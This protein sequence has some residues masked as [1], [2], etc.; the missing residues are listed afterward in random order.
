[1]ADFCTGGLWQ[2]MVEV[3]IRFIDTEGAEMIRIVAAFW[4][5]V[6]VSGPFS[7]ALAGK[8][9]AAPSCLAFF[10]DIWGEGK[11][12]VLDR[13]IDGT[14]IKTAS[15]F[16][17]VTG[18][19][20]AGLKIIKGGDFSGW[21][22][23]KIPLANICFE[24]TKLAGANFSNVRARGIGFI[25]SD[26]SGSNMRGAQMPAILLRN[27]NLTNVEAQGAD[28]SGGQ[29]DGGWF[30]GGI[31]GWN[32]D[33]A[34][35]TGFTFDCGITLSDGCPVYQGGDPVRANRANFTQANLDSFGLYN[36]E[37][38]GAILDRTII[39]PEQ[40]P[41]LRGTDIRGDV[42]FKGGDAE[43]GI[44]PDEMTILLEKN[45]DQ[46]VL[47]AN[48][49]F[50]CFDARSKVE[51]E[52]CGEYG[53]ELRLAD[54]DIA[55]LYRQAKALD[56]SVKSS[57][58]RWLKLRNRCNA[59][60]YA[61]QCIRESYSQRKGEL[62]GILGESQWLALGAEA[63]FV[64]DVLPLPTGF[65]Q[66]DLFAKITPAL[67]SAS[68]TDIMVMRGADGLYTIKGTAVGAN[69]H[70]CSLSASHLYFD[71]QSGWYI[72]VSEGRVTPIFRIFQD[73]LEIF[74][75]GRPDYDKYPGALDFISCGMRASFS[76]TRRIKVSAD[77]LA[78]YRKSFDE[79]M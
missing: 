20:E 69:A 9:L 78:R 72:P 26:L 32:I 67:V 70:M 41:E 61:I 28:F 16:M 25:A 60:E 33:G 37:L 63:L 19:R 65:A 76:E 74:E 22:F 45:A 43:V 14:S 52:I 10:G 71:T 55:A 4:G 53:E 11:N 24:E 5:M 48:P 3:A 34:N 73:R 62:L 2:H 7:P 64:S 17:R 23:S 15:D 21:D 44:S 40:L 50:D 58:R 54:R 56:T 59:E 79:D 46:E 35:L 12:A 51:E 31:A 29:F 6:A 39:G 57:Q 77:I 27:A 49:S 1:M 75:N 8:E 13:E 38:Q 66:T 68:M 30:E 47:A 42:I 18:T 36:V